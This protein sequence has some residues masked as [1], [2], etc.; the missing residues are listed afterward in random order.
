LRLLAWGIGVLHAA[1]FSAEI[2]P[3]FE[4]HRWKCHGGAAQP[5]SVSLAPAPSSA[6]SPGASAEP[7]RLCRS[8]LGTC[9]LLGCSSE[10]APRK[11]GVTSQLRVESP[12]TSPAT[13]R[14]P[15]EAD[16]NEDVSHADAGPP[17]V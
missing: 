2:H 14:S 7:D 17:H 16:E 15:F 4:A 12:L 11:Y 5:R 1:D 6:T 3:I 8:D 9:A 10:E 13:Q